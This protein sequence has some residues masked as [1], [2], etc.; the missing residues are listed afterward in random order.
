[1]SF[2]LLIYLLDL[3]FLM[4]RVNVF[5]KC[6][7]ELKKDTKLNINNYHN[8]LDFVNITQLY[9]NMIKYIILLHL[10]INKNVSNKH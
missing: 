7:M 3:K 10:S 6:K 9:H 1:M 2:S 4:N 8:V 5:K